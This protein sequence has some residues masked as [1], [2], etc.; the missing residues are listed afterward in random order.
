[1]GVAADGDVV[2][3]E[4]GEDH[5]EEVLT[6]DEAAAAVVDVM[7]ETVEICR[8][9]RETG[10]AVRAATRTLRGATSATGARSRKLE[11]EEEAVVEGEEEDLE[12]I[13]EDMA[14]DEVAEEE[15]EAMEVVVVD[16]EIVIRDQ[17]VEGEFIW[18]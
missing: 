14:A 10:S 4:S 2:A 9:A 7:E 5:A 1:M 12:E 6:L 17:C 3:V 15:E 11:E 8:S 13:V 16:E 18:H